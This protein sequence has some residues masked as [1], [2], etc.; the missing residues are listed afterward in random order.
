MTKITFV[1]VEWL[2]ASDG[3]TE[4]TD[5]DKIEPVS[6]LVIRTTYG[7]LIKEDK[8][9]IIVGLTEDNENIEY[10]VIPKSCISS[11]KRIRTNNI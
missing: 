1:A 7:K 9:A 3:T 6:L 2:D 11:I 10:T 8:E 5:I 4:D